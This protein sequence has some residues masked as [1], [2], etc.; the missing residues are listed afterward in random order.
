[1]LDDLLHRLERN[2]A[3]DGMARPVVDAVGPML[4]REE[5]SRVLSGAWLGHQLHPLLT[6]VVIGTWL[7]AS[8]LDAVGGRPGQVPAR[9]LVGAGLLAAVPTTASGLHDWLDQGLRIRRVGEV[10]A[11]ANAVAVVLQVA[12]WMAR[13]RGAQVRGAWL[14]AGALAAT[15]V[16]G[17]LGGHLTYVL[18]AGVARTAFDDPTEDWTPALPLSELAVGASRAVDVAGTP[19]LLVHVDDGVT[20]IADTCTHAGCSLAEGVVAH[21]AVTCPCHGSRF[22]LGDGRTLA[23][24]AAAAQPAYDT[25]VRSGIIEVR[26][27]Q[28][29][30]AVTVTAG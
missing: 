24:P 11:V 23:G 6:D 27:R 17:Y 12:S 29:D 22:R 3:L 1:M 7:S 15:G 14:S 20:A 10:H 8:V 28:P 19:V 9:R 2:E 4:R 16:G 25:R 18:G 30:A 21:G 5:V 13:R 26:E